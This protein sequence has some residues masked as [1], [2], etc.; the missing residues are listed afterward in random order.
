MSLNPR[1]LENGTG[2]AT[3][4]AY[5]GLGP[6][7]ATA[8]LLHSEGPCAEWRLVELFAPKG[9]FLAHLSWSAG[10]G[11]GDSISIVGTSAARVCVFARS[12]RIVGGNLAALEQQVSAVVCDLIAPLPTHNQ[13]YEELVHP[14]VA[15]PPRHAAGF[16]VEYPGGAAQAAASTIDVLD[17]VGVV[18]ASYLGNAQ[19][20][21]WNPLGDAASIRV[22]TGAGARFRV[23]YDLTL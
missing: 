22:T 21:P 5:P 3:L 7:L 13:W 12:L 16:R 11:T 2:S 8:E 23:V 19:V 10:G 17:G 6:V 9:T 4:P 14:A 1:P 15:T 18:I 20:Q